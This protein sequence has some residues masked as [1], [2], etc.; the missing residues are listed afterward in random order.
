MV[1]PDDAPCACG[2]HDHV[3]IG[4][5]VSERL[6]VLPVKFQVIVTCRPKDAC[7]RGGTASSRSL[8]R[9]A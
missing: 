3:R 1:E 8:R 4:K 2:S 7:K 5:D 9:P 6:D